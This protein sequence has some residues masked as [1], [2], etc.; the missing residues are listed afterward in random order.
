MVD[1]GPESMVLKSWPCCQCKEGGDI[2]EKSIQSY[3]LE[4]AVAL[5]TRAVMM[6]LVQCHYLG[7]D[8]L[9]GRPLQR[10]KFPPFAIVT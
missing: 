10:T 9:P 1:E 2:G 5:M 6:L 7:Y 4:I 3:A 8:H